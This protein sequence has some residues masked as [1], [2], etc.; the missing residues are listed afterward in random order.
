MRL[1]I[2]TCLAALLLAAPVVTQ[3]RAQDAAQDTKQE[4]VKPA[5]LRLSVR[6]DV[7]Q[8]PDIAIFSVGSVSQATTAKQAV[9]DNAARMKAV[10]DGLAKA[11]IQAKDM[12]TGQLT[13]QPEYQYEQKK[14]PKLTGYR[15]SNSVEI[16]LRDLGKAGSLLDTL[17]ELG[18]NE[19][20]GPFFG[21]E[22]PEAALDEARQK[23]MK[24]AMARAKLYAE[25]AGLKV[26][27]VRD[28]SEA[29]SHGYEAA[30]PMVRAAAP[31]AMKADTPVAPGE[32]SAE[33][34]LQVTFELAP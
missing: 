15:A 9:S 33:I 27:R 29:S 26:A 24:T 32:V 8:A 5:T 20:S 4:A 2:A 23:A 1:P 13:L 6:A 19:I 10:F 31:M 28:I 14:A 18:A 11:G 22:H 12:Q 16:R 7:K 30:R 21:M 3:A 25:A 17:T 34:T